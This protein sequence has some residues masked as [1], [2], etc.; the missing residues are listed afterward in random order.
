MYALCSS[1]KFSIGENNFS[2][3]RDKI[4]ADKHEKAKVRRER[5]IQQKKLSAL[6]PWTARSKL[7]VPELNRFSERLNR[8]KKC[9]QAVQKQCN[10]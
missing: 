4:L 8:K 10:Y 1:L 2:A 6:R 5:I 7:D 3:D 9:N